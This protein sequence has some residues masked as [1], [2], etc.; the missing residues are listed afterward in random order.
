MSE[1]FQ[2]F[3]PTE[4]IMLGVIIG[5]WLNARARREQG[6]RIGLLEEKLA[7]LLAP[8]RPPGASS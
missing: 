5:Q 7:A 1:L 8:P 2:H 6:Q 3:R 4:W